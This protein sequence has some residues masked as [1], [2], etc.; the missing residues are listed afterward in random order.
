MCVHEF[1][2][3]LMRLCAIIAGKVNWKSAQNWHHSKWTSR[4]FGNEV[5]VDAA[6]L[7]EN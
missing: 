1:G 6:T 2:I 4:V 3:V 5:R 7:H